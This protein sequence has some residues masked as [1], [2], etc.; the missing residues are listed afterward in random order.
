MRR[1]GEPSWAFTLF[2]FY[3]EMGV[4]RTIRLVA[5][6]AN[7]TTR[8]IE[9]MAARWSWRLRA[10]EY[11]DYYAQIRARQFHRQ[12]LLAIEQQAELGAKMRTAASEGLDVLPTDELSAVE[13]VR[14]AETGVKIERLAYGESTENAAPQEIKFVL[15][16]VPPWA[17]GQV[18]QVAAGRSLPAPLDAR[19]MVAA[20][21]IKLQEKE[22]VVA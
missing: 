16:S 13:I 22:G 20:T 7:K 12:R 18:E 19:P 17:K 4:D 6:E 2:E 8:N 21:H 15:Q 9:K 11:D 5:E 1:P 10:Q 14:L 3:R